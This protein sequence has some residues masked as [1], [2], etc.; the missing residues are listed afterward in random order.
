[1]CVVFQSFSEILPR[2]CSSLR[3]A[4]VASSASDRVV[5]QAAA[6]TS[7]TKAA[8]LFYPSISADGA[9][10]LDRARPATRRDPT[11]AVRPLSAPITWPSAAKKAKCEGRSALPYLRTYAA[12]HR[13]RVGVEH[14]PVDAL[15]PRLLLDGAQA[16]R[17]SARHRGQ[18][19][20]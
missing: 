1:M 8:L 14:H 17:A 7:C 16:R 2:G 5:R 15:G 9:T 18:S 11:S 3:G 12:V 6:N 4:R 13:R 10:A 20:R 19:G